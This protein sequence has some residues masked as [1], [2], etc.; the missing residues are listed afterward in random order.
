MSA[1][2]ATPRVKVLHVLG[3]I[4]PSGAETMLASAS[5]VFSDAGIT[6]AALSTG[7]SVGGFAPQLATRGFAIHH[8]PFG[9]S[10]RFF[11]QFYK[12]LKS[13]RFDVVHI[14]SERA[15]FYFI[16]I[17]W[18]ARTPRIIRTVHHIFPWAGWLRWRALVQRQIAM[19]MFGVVFIS[20]STSGGENELRCYRMRNQII[21][22]WYD[23]DIFKPRSREQYNRA[24]A[25]LGLSEDYFVLVS[26]GGN[27]SYKNYGLVIEAMGLLSEQT[28]V[29]YLQVGNQGSGDPLSALVDKF[30]T[31]RRVRC[32][33]RVEEPLS[34]LNAADCYIM[35]SS[36]EGFG[37]AAAEA[38]AVGV[39]AI[40]SNRPALKDFAS[41]AKGI[42]WV[43]CDPVSIA[44]AVAQLAAESPDELWT[45]GQALAA[46]MPGYC[47]LG[48]GPKM[49]CELYRD[50]EKPTGI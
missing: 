2:T 15:F 16:L 48:V 34:Y 30:S 18:L 29:L 24:R 11:A 3:A 8:I 20:N 21:P 12:L 28:N 39:P 13:E 49:F 50:A 40:L 17:A 1:Q 10:L 41:A 14:H 45:R 9:R 46:K 42:V 38:M 43:E 27:S 32:C 7:E 25:G 31:S 47:G 19:R 6:S 23:S 22:N 5:Q 4:L 44:A 37:V 26:L 35:P 33:G 36:I